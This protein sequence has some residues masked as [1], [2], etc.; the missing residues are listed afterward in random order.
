MRPLAEMATIQI[1]I[2][3]A[4]PNRCSNCTRFCGHRPPYFMERGSLFRPSIPSL[5]SPT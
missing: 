4:C 1:D 5:I 2:T 3:N